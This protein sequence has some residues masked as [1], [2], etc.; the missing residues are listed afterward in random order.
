MENTKAKQDANVEKFIVE[1]KK[2]QCLWNVT[3]DE[4]KD[5]NLKE[6]ALE[7]LKEIFQIS[8]K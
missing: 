5:R 6:R 2:H 8:G 3:S 7:N 1:W 4:Y